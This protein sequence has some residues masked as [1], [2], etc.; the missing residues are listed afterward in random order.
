MTDEL[1]RRHNDEQLSLL[2]SAQLLRSGLPHFAH[3][4][5]PRDE[6]GRYIINYHF[7]NNNN[8][9]AD[10]RQHLNGNVF[11]R[12]FKPFTDQAKAE[13]AILLG[14]FEADINLKF[15]PVATTRDAHL[16]FSMA[17][18]APLLRNSADKGRVVSGFQNVMARG[19]DLP[20]LHIVLLDERDIHQAWGGKA[21]N[22]NAA[23]SVWLM[24][25]ETLH[26]VGK[27]HPKGMD[28]LGGVSKIV[29][30][31]S[32]NVTSQAYATAPIGNPN[33]PGG[34]DLFYPA[35]PM[36][37][38]F[39]HAMRLYGPAPCQD[40]HIRMAD[41]APGTKL[42]VRACGERNSLDTTPILPI[43][44][45]QVIDLRQG[46]IAPSDA[47]WGKLFLTPDFTNQPPTHIHQVKGHEGDQV[48]I[49]SFKGNVRIKGGGGQDHYLVYGPNVVIHDESIGDKPI[50]TLHSGAE[51]ALHI[52][53]MTKAQ[54]NFPKDTKV[55][56][57]EVEGTSSLKMEV[58]FA[59]GGKAHAVI[60]SVIHSQKPLT[61][62][63]IEALNRE[64]SDSVN[65]PEIQWDTAVTP[66]VS[67]PAPKSAPAL[68]PYL[69]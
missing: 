45:K 68:K 36:A 24:I 14:R 66:P 11:S 2:R 43:K 23:Q 44:G 49:T 31:N 32:W 29:S 65:L 60:H 42:T 63:Q 12:S 51:A 18:I 64:Y 16:V 8:I 41:I 40:T 56:L 5:H 19:D 50:I 15:V 39:G 67:T 62:K 55:K 58:N 61:K 33:P 20:H 22:E 30:S 52:T 46:P 28:P 27:D 4:Y 35:T 6:K 37:A 26:G 13:I 53:D 38:D 21:G 17:E 3:P 54:F 69:P 57:S 7:L 10:V 47:Y 48:F 34:N 9:L 25:H 1:H 59:D